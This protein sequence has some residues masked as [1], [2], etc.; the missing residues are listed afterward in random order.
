MFALAV[1][2]RG[3]VGDDGG[4]VEEAAA[5]VP[6][7]GEVEEVGVV[8]AGEEEG[9]GGGGESEEAGAFVGVE[10]EEVENVGLEEAGF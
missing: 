9:L 2:E 6:G 3:E 8:G 1:I 5:V 7:E 10:V 4:G